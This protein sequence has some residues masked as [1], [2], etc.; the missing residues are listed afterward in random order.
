MAPLYPETM[1]TTVHFTEESPNQ[2]RVTVTWEP[3]GNATPEEISAFEKMRA[4]MTLGWTGSFDKL[5]SIVSP[6]A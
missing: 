2:T 1:L 6:Q 4:G 5:E 3:Y